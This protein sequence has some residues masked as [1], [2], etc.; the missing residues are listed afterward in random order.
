MRKLA[1]LL[2]FSLT[3]CPHRVDFGRFGRLEDPLFIL[4]TLRGR[5]EVV[6]GLVGE[7][8][9][10]VDTPD[11][12]GTLRMAVEVDEPGSI[13]LETADIVGTPRGVFATDGE[14]FAFYD[15]GQNV[16]WTGPATA[17]LMGQ[18][19]P[20]SLPPGQL[21]SAML[22]EIP[23]LLEPDDVRM[24]LDDVA[25]IY[26]IHTRQGRV[27][28]RIEVATRDLRLISVETRGGPAIDAFLDDHEE[29]IP[30]LPFPTTVRLLVPGKETEVTLRY[31][32]IRLN[33]ASRPASFV[34][35]PPEGAKVERL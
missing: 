21:V 34:L 2:L 30:G 14:E 11:V 27:R 24:E 32:D 7:G 20:V 9:L 13:Y 18:F 3:A 4:D 22:G 1:F 31:T 23:L 17:E 16:F 35:S 33:Q 26:V 6:D 5:Y 8:K 19:L 12:D 25:G 10:A 15:P 29:L 28:Q